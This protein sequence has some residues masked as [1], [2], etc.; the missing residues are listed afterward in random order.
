[1]R[2]ET[3]N[4]NSKLFKV[5]GFLATK[6]SGEGEEG[7]LFQLFAQLNTESR[8]EALKVS[9]SFPKSFKLKISDWGVRVSVNLTGD[10]VNGGNNESGI[11]RFKR[12]LTKAPHVFVENT[13][14]GNSATIKEFED[15]LER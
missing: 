12:F 4:S 15:F 13:N 1:M 5:S 3:P 10:N 7:E 11:K 9:A 6:E 8:E 14:I 2:N